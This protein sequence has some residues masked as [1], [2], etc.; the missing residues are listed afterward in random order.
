MRQHFHLPPLVVVSP[1]NAVLEVGLEVDV[2]V[3]VNQPARAVV[4]KRDAG[5]ALLRWQTGK[6]IDGKNF[7]ICTSFKFLLCLLLFNESII[8]PHSIKIALVIG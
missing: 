3:A 5:R 2:A 6:A 7:S 1:R 8:N 4:A